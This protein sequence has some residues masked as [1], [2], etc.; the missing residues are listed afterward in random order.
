MAL[1][2]NSMPME[3][4]KRVGIRRFMPGFKPNFACYYNIKIDKLLRIWDRLAR[5]FIKLARLFILPLFG[6]FELYIWAHN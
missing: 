3:L 6:F 2:R 1:G 5:L 4:L